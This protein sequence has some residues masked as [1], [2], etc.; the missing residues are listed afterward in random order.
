MKIDIKEIIAIGVG[1]LLPILVSAQ[2]APNDVT[3]K[4]YLPPLA[5]V[6]EGGLLK[7]ELLY[8]IGNGPTE[9]VHSSTLI[10][11]PDGIVVAF[12]A[13]THEKNPD[14]GIRVSRL[15]DGSWTYPVEVANGFQNENLRYPSWN[16]VLFQAEGKPLTL[17]YKIGPDPRTWWGMYLQSNDNGKSWSKPRKI[18]QD[19]S[20]GNLI[21]PV[22]NKSVQLNSGRIINPTSLEFNAGELQQDWQVYFEISDDGGETWKVVGPVHDGEAFDAIQPSILTYPEGKIQ[23]ISRTKQGVLS[24]VW[25]YDQGE[26]WGEMTALKL[27]NP[28]SGTDAVTLKDGTQLLVYNH[29]TREGKEPKDRNILNLA[30]SQN[31]HDWTPVMT[32]ENVPLKDG[33][34]YPSIIQASDG[35]VHITYTYG[36]RTIK[37]VVVNPSKL[38]AGL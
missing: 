30:I 26:T 6:G 16:P 32:L 3:G 21:G 15:V 22:K 17:F 4:F 36:R 23:A 38:S 14:V 12:F 19:P 24:Q 20:I 9:Q 11:T 33:Y 35:L 29:S 13:G 25:S 18:G 2:L 27:P 1:C 37:Y 10:E 8:E 31:G 34:A 7:S 28:N 5:K